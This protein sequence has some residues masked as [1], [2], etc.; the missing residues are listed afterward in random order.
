MKDETEIETVDGHSAQSRAD[1]GA[2][3]C[4][5]REDTA[6]T[7]ILFHAAGCIKG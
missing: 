6:M 3:A 7:T 5:E 2:D 1:V 4:A